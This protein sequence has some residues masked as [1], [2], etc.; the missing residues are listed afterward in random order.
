MDF[1]NQNQLSF[2]NLV[3]I[4]CII[5]TLSES[6]RFDD[7]EMNYLVQNHDFHGNLRLM[8]HRIVD[9]MHQR[10]RQLNVP[11]KFK[12]L[13]IYQTEQMKKSIIES[14]K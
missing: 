4:K 1:R 2:D 6:K 5:Q 12:A 11:Q 9:I 7:D 14:Y 8:N 10:P 13:F 3:L